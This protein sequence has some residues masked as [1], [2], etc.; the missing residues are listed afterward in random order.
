MLSS[1]RRVKVAVTS[2]GKCQLV[3]RS[4]E[5]TWNGTLRLDARYADGTRSESHDRDRVDLRK[6]FVV[7]DEM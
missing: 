1:G 2:A 7:V 5:D 4:A 3:G 6:G